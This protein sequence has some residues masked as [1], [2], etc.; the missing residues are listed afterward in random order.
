M[1][2]SVSRPSWLWPRAAYIHIPFCAHH[3]GYC[4]F[5]VAVGQDDRIDAYLD[6]L[7]AE[8]TR[9]EAPQK[10][11]T[12]FFG[13]G[14][15]SHLSACQL[16]KL[17]AI[18]GRWFTLAHGHEFSL[19][20]NPSSL[21]EAKLQLL[22]G[23]GV[24]RISLGV[25]S[26]S[27]SLLR[28]LERDHA[29]ADAAKAFELT[30]KYIPNV[31][32]DLIFGV[33]GQTLENWRT[34]LEEAAAL[35]PSHIATYGLTYEKGTRLWK[36]ER[37]GQV[38]KLSEDTE[39]GLY[40]FAMDFLEQAGFEHYEISNF[41]RAGFHCRHNATYWAN[42]AYFG[43]GMGAARYVD[44]V[45]QTNVRELGAYIDRA[46]AGKPTHFQSEQLEP[47]DRAFETMALQLR[48]AQGID[49]LGFCAQTGFTVED[50]AGTA[51]KKLEELELLAGDVWA[52]HLTRKGKCLADAVVAQLMAAK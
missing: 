7:A 51:M 38:Q 24:N 10:V 17:L 23:H 6:A 15:P 36:Q 11:D 27:A 34:D 26:F 30:R 41:A 2:E 49:R 31:S 12:L 46:S 1:A 19:E 50:L 39:L 13:G 52:V 32:L 48:R 37:Q 28:V 43:F 35:A 20:A 44:G 47:R 18:V 25:Q 42:E 40:T 14:T 45:R 5:A 9:L 3:C 4:D 33:P 22:A 29:P 21:D 16:E 8:L